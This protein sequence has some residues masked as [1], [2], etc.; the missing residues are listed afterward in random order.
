MNIGNPK[1]NLN[2]KSPKADQVAEL[3]RKKG[4]QETGEPDKKAK[5][6]DTKDHPSS[7]NPLERAS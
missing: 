3:R 5:A 6:I 2:E 1:W 4:L 7:E